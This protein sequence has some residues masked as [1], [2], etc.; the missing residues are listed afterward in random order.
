MA[1]EREEAVTF[2]LAQIACEPG[3]WAANV[4]PTPEQIKAAEK[5]W[6]KRSYRHQPDDPECV[7]QCG[8][9]RYFAAAGAD[10]GV[11]WNEKSP[12]DGCVT[13]EHGGC[14]DHSVSQEG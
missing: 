14:P 5:R 6:A 13:F 1:D 8:G 2:E 10:Y 4:A 7:F 9:C 12:L 11:C 3:G